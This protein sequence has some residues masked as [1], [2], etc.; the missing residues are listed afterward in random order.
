MPRKIKQ[1]TAHKSMP[2]L[3]PDAAGVD[4]GAREIYVAV[5]ADRD[6]HPVRRFAT[7][8]ADLQAI[9][10]WLARCRI[11]TVAAEATGVYWIPLFQIRQVMSCTCRRRWIR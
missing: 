5:P 2:V 3:Q 11:R 10:D 1:P 9:A 8:T 4:I 7:F 6:P